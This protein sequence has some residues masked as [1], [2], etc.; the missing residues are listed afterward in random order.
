M[1]VLRYMLWKSVHLQW[2]VYL[3]SEGKISPSEENCF[4]RDLKTI[5]FI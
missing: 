1:F 2:E 4:I 5:K 3:I